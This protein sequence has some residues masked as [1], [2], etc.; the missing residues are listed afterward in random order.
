MFLQITALRLRS[1]LTASSTVFSP[2][3]HAEA[4]CPMSVGQN[5]RNESGVKITEKQAMGGEGRE[6]G[7]IE[8]S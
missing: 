7:V 2:F 3:I 6:A 1:D 5:E 8:T 4:T